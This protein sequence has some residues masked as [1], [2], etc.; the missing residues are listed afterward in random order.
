MRT[1]THVDPWQP[2]GSSVP[3]PGAHR[4]CQSQ[5]PSPAPGRPMLHPVPMCSAAAQSRDSAVAPPA[6]IRGPRALSSRRRP[7]LQTS[8]FMIHFG[9]ARPSRPFSHLR[10]TP[11][12]S[13]ATSSQRGG[14]AGVRAP[15]LAAL[16]LA[17]CCPR[18]RASTL[19]VVV[20]DD[21]SHSA[22]RGRKPR[23]PSRTGDRGPLGRPRCARRAQPCRR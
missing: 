16:P 20:H 5:R 3:R 21:T 22:R 14:G 18:R 1:A 8:L 9:A 11:R 15:P 2:Q 12:P 17:T 19:L 23:R 7:H 13:P 4:D 10:P 6:T